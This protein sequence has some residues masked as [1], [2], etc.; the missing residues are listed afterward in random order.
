MV[1][2]R[3]LCTFALSPWIFAA[4][5]PSVPPQVWIEPPVPLPAGPALDGDPLLAALLAARVGDAAEAADFL[6]ARPRPAPDPFA[7]PGLAAAAARVRRAVEQG[8]TIAVYGDYDVDGV[9]SVALL[10]RTLRAAGVGPGRLLPKLPTRQEGYGLNP[11]AVDALAEAGASLLIAVDCASGDH[12]N[13]ARARA[14]GMDVVVLDHHQLPGPPPAGAVVASAQLEPGAPYAELA[15]VGVAY[16]LAVAL[17]RGG[18]DA[19]DGPGAEPASLL[20]LVA[21]GT[22]ADVAPLT[23]ANRAL[24]RDG[25]RRLGERPS[26]GVLALCRRAGLPPA[27]LTSEQIAF[28]LAPRLNAAGRMAHPRLALK[29]LLT[30][31]PV[32]ADA[33]AQELESLNSRRRQESQRIVA[34]AEGMVGERPGLADRRLLVLTRPGWGGGVAGLAAGRLVE[35]FGRPVVVLSDDGE[36]SRGSARSVPGFD[37]ARAL[38]ACGDLLRAHG[39]HSQAAGLTLPTADVPRL[40]AALEAALLA[41][42]LPAPGPPALRI[43]AD[44]PAERISLATADLLAQ[45]EPF[46]CGNERPLLRL[47]DLPVH[48]YATMGQ[49]GSHLKIRLQTPRGPVHALCWGAAARSRELLAQPRLDLVVSLSLDYWNGSRRLQVEAKDF[50]PSA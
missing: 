34:E 7:L 6:D 13:V 46:G 20:D 16:L 1:P 17:A 11:E 3:R 10:L 21:L 48:S 44:L 41:A 39:G 15:A 33:L 28:K 47:R 36:L 19:G 40:E 31:D 26:P 32:E 22:V 4:K 37:I 14:R 12:A 30:R 50:R 24:V 2:S 42:D 8:E 49:D 23:G 27:A 38:S 5:E 43:D 45:L 18:L 9:A 35:R 25:L 29:L